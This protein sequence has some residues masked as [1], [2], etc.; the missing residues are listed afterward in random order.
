MKIDDCITLAGLLMYK[1][2]LKDWVFK[3]GKMKRLAGACSYRNKRITLSCHYITNNSNEDIVDTILHE[4]AH[5]LVGP[6]NGHNKTWKAKC[7]EIGARPVR[8]Y[9]EHIKMVEGKYIGYCDQ[10]GET[11]YRHRALRKGK[12]NYHLACGPGSEIKWRVKR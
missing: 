7:I 3:V 6:G 2:N 10:C 8:C 4:I 11:F 5:A 12:R 9:G 1:H